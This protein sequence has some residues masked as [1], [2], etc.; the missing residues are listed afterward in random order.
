MVILGDSLK[1]RYR[2][3]LVLLLLGVINMA[4]TLP[5]GAPT[6]ACETLMPFHGGGILPQTEISP[7]VVSPRR[8]GND[9][10]L[11][12]TSTVNVPFQGFLIQGRTPNGEILGTFNS[13]SVNEGHPLN[14][15]EEAD[16]LTHNSPNDKSSISVIWKPPQDY[17]GPVI[18]NSTIAQTYDTFWVGVTSEPVEITKQ[19]A[20]DPYVNLS[21]PPDEQTPPN[22]VPF[23]PKES[24]T[25]FDPF[26]E[27]CSVTKLCFGA[28]A[29]CVASQNCKSVVA[30]TVTGEKYDF[31]LKA[32]NNA[33]WV[34]VGLSADDKM[35]DDSVIECVKK[36]TGVSAYMSETTVPNYGSPRLSNPQ[37][38]IQM[39]NSSLV[40]GVIYCKVRRDASTN[41]NG[42]TYDLVNDKYNLLIAAGSS[43]KADSV[44]FHDIAYL[45]SAESQSLADVSALAAKSKLLIRLHGCFMLAAW[46]GTASIGIL[47]ARYYR[48][49]WVG[50]Q[51]FGKDMWFAWHRTLMF[52]TWCLTIVAFVLIF[53]EL[54]AW[55]GE[56]NPHAILGTVTTI[57]CFIQPIGAYFRP[58]P[59]TP[60][61]PIFN[62][63]HWGIGNA[64]H[65]IGIVT[66]F[67]A[68]K[69]TKAEL[70]EF[71]D[72]ILV[73]YVVIH[74]ISHLALSVLNCLAEKSGDNRVTSFPMKDLAGSGRTS[75]FT[76]R[77]PDAPF[78]A[79]RKF[80]LAVYILVII[81]IVV[82]LIVITA[83]APIEEAWSNLKSSVTNK[84]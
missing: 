56:R 18:F 4:W 2:M 77:N 52:L 14:C 33:A 78:S 16:S 39:L 35:G 26:Y 37:L 83:L 5:Q 40:D 82:A 55:S 59:G 29:G 68:V 69:L 7:Y 43:V 71:V 75:G 42:K 60:K 49:T 8:Q 44:S 76:D 25:Q 22:F 57:L 47:L 30:V 48:Q 36:G 54:K 13:A 64:A 11:T 53:V 73:A 6:S 66:L 3:H 31:E 27:G 28:P 81:V 84:N 50:Q 70:P 65:I 46:L 79:F 9:V 1:L 32:E 45:A 34:G 20:N 38:G 15:V 10:K 21:T 61:R 23:Q 74:V 19:G 17:E 63:L 62:W 72:W 80:L 41:V 12:V 67:F 24:S 58:H 51:M